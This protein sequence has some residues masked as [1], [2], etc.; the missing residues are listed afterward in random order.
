MEEVAFAGSYVVPDVKN[1]SLTDA[2]YI[3]E[4][5][6]MTAEIKTTA[7]K[8]NYGRVKKQTPEPNAP[9]P[10]NRKMILELDIES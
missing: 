10:R 1:M 3:L 8:K 9:F 7:D 4:R 5:A 2:I 6:G